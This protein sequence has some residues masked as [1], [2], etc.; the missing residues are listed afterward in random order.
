MAAA[1]VSNGTSSPIRRGRGGRWLVIAILLLAAGFAAWTWVTLNW[2]YSEGERAGVLQKF[3]RRGWIC[4]TDEGELAMYIVAGVAPQIW[5]FTV[6]DP[7][8]VAQMN[9]N[10]GRRVQL[11]YTEHRGIPSSCFGDTSYFVDRVT[12]A[13][14]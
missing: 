1:Q 7:A 6:R 9:R 11:H 5:N 3:S 2:S 12:P 8:I 14:N 13:E 10:V 4:K